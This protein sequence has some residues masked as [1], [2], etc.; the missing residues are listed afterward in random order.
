MESGGFFG[1][2]VLAILCDELK[3]R[4]AAGEG[5][6][7]GCGHSVPVGTEKLFN[8]EGDCSPLSHKFTGVHR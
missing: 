8:F 2:F 5:D 1:C 7:P 6:S 3:C 4:I